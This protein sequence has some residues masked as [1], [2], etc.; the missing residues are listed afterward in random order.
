ML[1]VDAESK[2]RWFGVCFGCFSSTICKNIIGK[3]ICQGVFYPQLDNREKT[4]KL[5]QKYA[6]LFSRL[7]ALDFALFRVAPI[8]K[9][10]FSW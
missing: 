5:T 10:H 2:T 4:L 8:A 6:K 9:P 3:S 1:V 7:F